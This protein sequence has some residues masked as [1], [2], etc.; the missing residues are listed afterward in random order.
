MTTTV[1]ENIR[2]L[3]RAQKSRAGAPLYS[4][5]VNR[6]VGRVLAAVAHRLGASPDQVTVLSALC[7][8]TGIALIALLRPGRRRRPA[9]PA[10]RRRLEGRGVAGPRGRRH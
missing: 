9:G 10:A 6:P 4:R 3:S 8:Y 7:T 2:A 5:V 1:S